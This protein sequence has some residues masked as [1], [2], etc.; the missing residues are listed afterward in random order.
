MGVSRRA[1]STAGLR[2]I[3]LYNA[4]VVSIVDGTLYMMLLSGSLCTTDSSYVFS[5][6]AVPH[7]DFERVHCRCHR[8]TVCVVL[9]V[10]LSLNY[11]SSVTTIPIRLLPIHL[12]SLSDSVVSLWSGF[13]CLLNTTV[14]NVL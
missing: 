5:Q 13:T 12:L 14:L 6:T 2:L 8:T 3:G 4:P 11:L 10:L 9:R 7:H 1:L